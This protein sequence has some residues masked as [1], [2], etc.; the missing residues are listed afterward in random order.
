MKCSV[1]AKDSGVRVAPEGDIDMHVAPE[2]RKVLRKVLDERPAAVT[3][4]LAKVPFLDSSGVATIVEALKLSRQRGSSLRVEGC[5]R[6][7][8]DT[9]E[10]AGL[11]KILGI[12]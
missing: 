6:S 1:E 9:F 8:R 12:P 7:V 11:T 10:I 4:D 2:F 3:V 5:S